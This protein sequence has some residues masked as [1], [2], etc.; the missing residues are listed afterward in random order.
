M[1]YV[2][3][4][5]LAFRFTGVTVFSGIDRKETDH[6]RPFGEADTTSPGWEDQ[7]KIV[8]HPASLQILNAASTESIYQHCPDLASG[9]EVAR[10]CRR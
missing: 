6:I 8:I 1:E 9:S 10:H 2:L 3:N 7:A 5:Y 4:P